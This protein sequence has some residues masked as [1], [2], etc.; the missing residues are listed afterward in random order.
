MA[1][2]VYARRLGRRSRKGLEVRVLSEAPVVV[3]NKFE[4]TVPVWYTWLYD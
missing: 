1:E 2:L 4:F 3:D